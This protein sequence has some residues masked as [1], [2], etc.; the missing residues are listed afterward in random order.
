[1]DLFTRPRVE[2]GN[3]L[4]LNNDVA[5]ANWKCEKP[6]I[7]S[8]LHR[9]VVIAPYVMTI[10]RLKLY[11]FLEMLGDRVLYFDTDSVIFIERPNEESPAVGD[12]LGDLTDEIT[13]EYGPTD[14]IEE[15]VSSG[16]RNYAYKV[17]LENVAFNTV[18]KLTGI[19]LHLKNSNSINVEVIK[20]MITTHAPK[21]VSLP[22]RGNIFRNNRFQVFTR[23][24]TKNYR[25]VYTVQR[26]DGFVIFTHSH[27]VTE[28]KQVL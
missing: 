24:E 7:T 3:V 27:L 25:V 14:Y 20:N 4:I 2:V 26:E 9:S 18:T 17:Q 23:L 21:F 15:F 1:M 11:S 19:N 16:P 10:A 13:P 6:A 8:S 5:M 12:Y 22:L 28:F